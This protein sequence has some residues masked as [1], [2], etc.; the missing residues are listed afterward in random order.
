[1]NAKPDDSSWLD[2]HIGANSPELYVT[3][4]YSRNILRLPWTALG[5]AKSKAGD[6]LNAGHALD[7]DV[8]KNKLLGVN[9]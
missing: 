4:V 6:R 3:L 7:G 9:T 1:M 2:E 5:S 8:D